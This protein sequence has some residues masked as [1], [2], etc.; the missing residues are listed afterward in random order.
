MKQILL[1]TLLAALSVNAVA[2]TIEMKAKA[3]V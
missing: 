3:V 1:T 2:D